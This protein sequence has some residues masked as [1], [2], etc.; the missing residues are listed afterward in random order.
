MLRS[1]TGGCL[2]HAHTHIYSHGH[3]RINEELVPR[4]FSL[5]QKFLATPSGPHCP[6]PL[7]LPEALAPGSRF[8]FK[9]NKCGCSGG[10]YLPAVERLRQED[11]KHE[12]PTV[13]LFGKDN[14][15]Q[16]QQ[17]SKPRLCGYH[18]FCIHSD[19][20]TFIHHLPSLGA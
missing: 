19:S 18:S 7:F 16:Q 8:H 17:T 6:T 12:L 14:N 2:L 4:L 10:P 11:N 20:G 3:T 1:K 13:K 5:T 9:I 15:T